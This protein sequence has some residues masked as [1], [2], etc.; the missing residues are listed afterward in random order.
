M[1]VGIFNNFPVSTILKIMNLKNRGGPKVACLSNYLDKKRSQTF[2][3]MDPLKLTSLK[4]VL[5][6]GLKSA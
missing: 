3:A 6:L 4:V 2:R 1:V 5:L